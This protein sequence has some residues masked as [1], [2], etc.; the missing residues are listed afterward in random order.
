MAL[1][2]REVNS[3]ALIL[4]LTRI[5]I[6]LEKLTGGEADIPEE[7]AA[8]IAQATADLAS[9]RVALKDAVDSNPST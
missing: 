1:S 7:L 6:A 8:A 3:A 4:V 9:N 2:V 5:A